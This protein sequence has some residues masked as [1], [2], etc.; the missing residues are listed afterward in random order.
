V[1]KVARR[2]ASHPGEAFSHSG[3]GDS[4]QAA[5]GVVD[6]QDLS[7]RGQQLQARNVVDGVSRPP[8]CIS[9]DDDFC[10]CVSDTA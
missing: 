10:F 4:R 5:V 7:D 8:A 6:D 9:D 3:V 2:L 1:S